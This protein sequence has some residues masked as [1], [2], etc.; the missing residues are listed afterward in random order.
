MLYQFIPIG[1]LAVLG[2][3]MAVVFTLAAVYLGPK[4]ITK[5]KLEPFECGNPS[6]GNP[7][8]RFSVKFYVVAVIFV[9]FDIEALFFFPWAVVFRQL[10]QGPGLL[11]LFGAIEMGLFLLVLAI[12]LYYAWRKGGLEWD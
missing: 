12:V 9:V 2:F 4:K 5:S 3:G 6:A 8:T 10:S 7:K 11:F 1:V